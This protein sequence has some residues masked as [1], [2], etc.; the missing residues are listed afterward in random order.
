MNSVCAD[1]R[2]AEGENFASNDFKNKGF[3][4]NTSAL[5]LKLGPI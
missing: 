4:N 3:Q 1:D 5:S 2:T